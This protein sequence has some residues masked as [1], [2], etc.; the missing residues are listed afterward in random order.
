MIEGGEI[1]P[2]VR[3][4]GVRAERAQQG[5]L[6]P[7][8][9]RALELTPPQL[10]LR[11]EHVEQGTEAHQLRQLLPGRGGFRA[12]AQ[13]NYPAAAI[14]ALAPGG[15][16][17]CVARRV[18]RNTDD[19]V[20]RAPPGREFRLAIPPADAHPAPRIALGQLTRQLEC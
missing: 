2:A 18:A 3:M 8:A 14:A 15:D 20:A 13:M 5:F 4:R 6:Q 10:R 16:A 7:G 9:A 19:D 11:L 17:R 12:Q 1:F